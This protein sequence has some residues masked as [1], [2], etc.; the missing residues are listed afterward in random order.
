MSDTTNF[1][2]VDIGASSGRVIL[3]R[4]DGRQFAL[5]ELHRFWNGP[6]EEGGHL[7]WEAGRLWREIQAGLAAY[8]RRDA[9]PLAGIGIDTWAVDYGLLDAEGRLLGNPFHYR[10]PRTAGMPALVDAQIPP[11]ELYAATGIQRLPL[12][13]LYQL[14]AA[15]RA[16]DGRLAAADTLL[17]MP[18][19]FHYWLTGRK[20]AEYTNAT[21]TM[22]LDAR[23]R[24]WATDLLDRLGLPAHILPPVVEPGTALGPL[25]PAVRDAAGLRHDA[26]V[27]AVG[28]H[29]TASAVAAVPGLDERS[30]YISSGTWSLV[31]VELGAPVLSAQAQR[32]NF[33]NEGGVAGTVR[34]LK[35]VAGLWLLQECRRQWQQE[36]QSYGWP[37]LVALAEAA[38]PL[39]SLVDPDA[40]E[41]LAVGDMPAT[42]RAACLRTG[43]PV[44][45][46]V[47]ALVRCCLESLALKYRWVVEALEGLTGRRIETVRVVGGGSQN[48]LLCQL[49]ADACKRPVVAGPAEGTALGNVLVQAI[50]TGHLPDL[51]A[52]RRAA[53][54]SVPQTLYAPRE[55]GDWDAAIVGFEALVAS[56]PQP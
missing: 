8:A 38:P 50:A 30:A 56:L 35:N 5:E 18:D 20:V 41:F 34:F 24:R 45:E 33:T 36:G 9:A 12:N 21:T 6:L 28:T 40:P 47:G 48:A 10:D 54:A 7:H 27:I 32:L 22:L 14:A 17:L 19:L 42:I 53:A 31:G 25:L 15:A 49:T 1:L 55:S 29:D 43:Q 4:W 44:P 26:P 16:A 13:T 23:E 52:G 11:A 37:E 46:S 3:A 39:R 51:A 2:A